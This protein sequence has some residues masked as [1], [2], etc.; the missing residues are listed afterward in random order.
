[1]EIQLPVHCCVCGGPVEPAYAGTGSG[2][3]SGGLDRCE[4]CFSAGIEKAHRVACQYMMRGADQL[5]AFSIR[6]A[7]GGVTTIVERTG[8]ADDD[9]RDPDH[10]RNLID[11]LDDRAQDAPRPSRKDQLASGLFNRRKR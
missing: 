2:V 11:R 1:M 6:G 3:G 7:G 10:Y 9:D 4:A 5:S 8:P